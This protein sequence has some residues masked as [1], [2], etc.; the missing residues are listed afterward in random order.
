MRFYCRIK[1]FCRSVAT[2]SNTGQNPELISEEIV[3]YYEQGKEA[4]RF[5]VSIGPLELARTKKPIRRKAPDSPAEIA[6]A[7]GGP[8]AYAC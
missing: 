5:A 2:M 1:P 7:G 4:A 3:R 8:G 6:D